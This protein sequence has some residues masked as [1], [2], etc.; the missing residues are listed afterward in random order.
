MVT[1]ALVEDHEGPLEDAR[2][3]IISH[4]ARTNHHHAALQREDPM[5]LFELQ[6]WLGHRSSTSTQHYAK[7]TPLTLVKACTGY[8]ARNVRA[9]EVLVDHGAVDSGAAASGTP[10]QHDDLAPGYY[11]YS[12]FVQCPHRMACARCDIYVP[13]HSKRDDVQEELCCPL[14]PLFGNYLRRNARD[15]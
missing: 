14:I 15:C 6:A 3:P 10:W 11:T 8:F 1:T 7:F 12:F 2:R 13:K 9:I 5:T 4:P